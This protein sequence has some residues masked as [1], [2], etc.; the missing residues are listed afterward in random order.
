MKQVRFKEEI[1]IIYV[2]SCDE[3]RDGSEWMQLARDRDRFHRRIIELSMIISPV[4]LKKR[5]LSII[6]WNHYCT[7]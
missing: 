6:Y 7:E 4:L 3:S 2:P 5:I 1:S